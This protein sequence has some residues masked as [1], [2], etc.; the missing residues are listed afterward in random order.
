[1]TQLHLIYSTVDEFMNRRN[2]SIVWFRGDRREPLSPY[3]DMIANYRSIPE[4]DRIYAQH[5]LDQMLT[6]S[7]MEEALNYLSTP[8]GG[9]HE[10]VTM[11]TPI[12]TTD[13]NGVVVPYSLMPIDGVRDVVVPQW[14]GPFKLSGYF[15]LEADNG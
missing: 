6:E 12:V 7:E 11:T 14:G 13:E 8:N 9:K 2:V 10:I 3:E 1:M 4:G 5:F 15:D